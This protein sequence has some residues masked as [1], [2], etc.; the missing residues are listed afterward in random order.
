MSGKIFVLTI[1]GCEVV[2]L[3]DKPGDGLGCE[4]GGHVPVEGAGDAAL[5]R[6]AE[7]VVPHGEVAPPLL[8]VHPHN[9]NTTN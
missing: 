9:Q 3:L 7:H 6:V 1:S 5:L 8:R 2:Q 4:L